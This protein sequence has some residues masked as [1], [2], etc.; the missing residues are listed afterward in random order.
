M[1]EDKTKKAAV[2]ENGIS[3]EKEHMENVSN[4]AA[5]AGG[6]R[7]VSA[8]E[9]KENGGIAG[10]LCKWVPAP[11]GYGLFF[12]SLALAIAIGLLVCLL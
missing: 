6:C 9:K 10:K 7:D 1:Q 5:A 8:G 3:A 4:T 12:G 11:L 2:S